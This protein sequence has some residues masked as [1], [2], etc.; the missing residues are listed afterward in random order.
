MYKNYVKLTIFLLLSLFLFKNIS[1]SAPNTPTITSPEDNSG[2]TYNNQPFILI[3]ASDSTYNINDCQIL[4]DNNSDFSSPEYDVWASRDT[5]YAEFTNLGAGTS[6]TIRHRVDS[7][8]SNGTYYIKAK[9]WN[10][11]TTG[12][13]SSWS[14]SV[15]IT[16]AADPSW[17]DSTIT[18]GSTLIKADHFNEL[19]TAID[20]LRLFRGNTTYSYANLPVS[21]GSLIKVDDTTDLRSAL[22]DP[23]NEATG[24]NPS[25]TDDPPTAGVTL[26]RAVHI[27]ELRSKVLLP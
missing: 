10:D 19:K 6:I 20:N 9:V 8:L 24:S 26:I 16:I 21:Y 22:T 15:Q 12:R 7:A 2:E 17:I 5:K 3:S 18:A 14:S 4:I 25:F 1:L 23:Y 27:T 13:E 11:N